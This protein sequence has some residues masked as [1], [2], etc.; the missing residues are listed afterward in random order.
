MLQQSTFAHFP[1][2]LLNIDTLQDL[3]SFIV[4]FKVQGCYVIHTY[5]IIY[6]WCKVVKSY[7][8]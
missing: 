5:Y 1:A 2:L 4:H 6:T 8:K 7:K 3:S